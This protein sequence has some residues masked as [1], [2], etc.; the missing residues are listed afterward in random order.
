MLNKAK[1]KIGYL[2]LSKN[3]VDITGWKDKDLG[4]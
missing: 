2:K 3:I 4:S 1:G